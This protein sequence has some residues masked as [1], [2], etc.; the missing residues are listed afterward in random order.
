M[1][2]PESFNDDELLLFFDAE[3]QREANERE[4]D[5]TQAIITEKLWSAIEELDV[6][7]IIGRDPALY[8]E[9]YDAIRDS[10]RAIT[11]PKQY[12]DDTDRYEQEIEMTTRLIW[13]K[14]AEIITRIAIAINEQLTDELPSINPTLK[15]ELMAVFIAKDFDTLRWFPLI[16]Y[17]LTGDAL[18]ENNT[19]DM[20][21]VIEAMKAEEETDVA[22]VA[23]LYDDIISLFDIPDLETVT[24]DTNALQYLDSVTLAARDITETAF[25]MAGAEHQPNRHD[26]LHELMREYNI[27]DTK[28]IQAIIKLT[29][30]F[31]S[32]E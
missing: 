30:E 1:T 31:T 27:T 17:V 11:D 4:L 14:E 19:E 3:T 26:K 5:Q 8:D 20:G 7:T 21:I 10:L 16:D 13:D 18:D 32:A 23:I 28:H 6:S 15:K 24:T 22:P 12:G 25:Y 29:D 2:S 9:Q